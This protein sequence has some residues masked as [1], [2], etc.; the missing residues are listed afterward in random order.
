MD[1]LMTLV[2]IVEFGAGVVFGLS[3][4]VC[5]YVSMAWIR[6][7]RGRPV[8]GNLDGIEKFAG[9]STYES[10]YVDAVDVSM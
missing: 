2:A 5:V 7:S 9:Q 10:F 1:D 3:I 8:V 4:A 6:L